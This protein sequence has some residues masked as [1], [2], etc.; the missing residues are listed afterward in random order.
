MAISLQCK[1][2]NVLHSY[3]GTLLFP[4]PAFPTANTEWHSAGSSSSWTTYHTEGIRSEHLSSP[5]VLLIRETQLFTRVISPFTLLFPLTEKK[6]TY[7]FS[8]DLPQ[9]SWCCIKQHCLTSRKWEESWLKLMNAV[10]STS[11][12]KSYSARQP[13]SPVGLCQPRNTEQLLQFC[14]QFSRVNSTLRTV[15]QLWFC[16]IQNQ[17]TEVICF[18]QRNSSVSHRTKISWLLMVFCLRREHPHRYSEVQ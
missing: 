11:E 5:V 14:H 16:K 6:W 7:I 10:I 13:Y 8:A 4:V 1:I 12:S 3:A 9:L 2:E 17:S 15:V 18:F